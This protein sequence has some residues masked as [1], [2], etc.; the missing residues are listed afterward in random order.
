M[1]EPDFFV[2]QGDE[3][4]VMADTLLN[5]LGAPVDIQGAT[6]KL[7]VYP[8]RGGAALIDDDAVNE[9]AGDGGDGSRGK[10]S[11]TWPAVDTTTPGTYVGQWQVTFGGGAVH[12]YPNGDYILILISA[13]PPTVPGTLYVQLEEFKSTI[14]M[15]GEAFADEDIA[16]SL[17]AASR[18][19]DYITGRRFYADA[20]ANQERWYTPRESDFLYINDLI[21][22]T[23]LMTDP[24]GDGTYEDT[25]A[26]TDYRLEP[27]NAVLDG[28]PFTLVRRKSAGS[29]RFPTSYEQ[30]VQVTGRFGWAT[31]P[32]EVREATSLLAHRLLKRKRESPTGVAGFGM[33]GATV[34]VMASDPDVLA[35]LQPYSRRPLVV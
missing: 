10:V 18:Q 32:A 6:V 31:V 33:D 21:E 28:R 35:L 2:R 15:K 16:A 26:A 24:D 27:L 14:S 23:S 17:A 34:R 1:A 13:D 8:I 30:S 3:G 25:W 4:F 29:F 22:L 5:E 19:A 12:T 9:Q 7:Q 20:D 11:F